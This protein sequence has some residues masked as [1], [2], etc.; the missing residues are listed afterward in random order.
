MVTR[1]DT[2]DCTSGYR[3]WRREALELLP[4][5]RVVSEGYAFLVEVLY[6]TA[7]R[8]HRIA[9][10]PI[11]FVERQVGKS[12]LSTAVLIESARAPWRLAASGRRAR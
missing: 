1:L 12:K 6:L 4:I 7:Q 8:G 5:D 3:C 10:V 11:T 9:E 2:R